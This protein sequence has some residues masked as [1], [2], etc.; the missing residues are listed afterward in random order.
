[1]ETE[2]FNEIHDMPIE[3]DLER[4]LTFE[5][6]DFGDEIRC[7]SD[8]S[9]R[10]H[11]EICIISEEKYIFKEEKLKDLIT[12][13]NIKYFSIKEYPSDAP[14]DSRIK[15]ENIDYAYICPENRTKQ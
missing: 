12:S 6:Y 14:I 1:M 10:G 9:V 8:K 3:H 4:V 13:D 7:Y 2:Y 11:F 5:N 15:H